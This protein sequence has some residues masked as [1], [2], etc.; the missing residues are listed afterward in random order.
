MCMR[1]SESVHTCKYTHAN[2]NEVCN[3]TY[4]MSHTRFATARNC[5]RSKSVPYNFR[6]HSSV[7]NT[8]PLPLRERY[9]ACVDFP[10][11][12]SPTNK[13]TVGFGDEDKAE[14]CA[15]TRCPDGGTERLSTN[16]KP[17]H[18]IVPTK[19]QKHKWTHPMLPLMSRTG[20]GGGGE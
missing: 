9:C 5:L 1:I 10:E 15:R 4:I 18:C 20:G 7:E 12:I 19:I 6:I 13:C 16:I 3:S 17:L 11:E 2:L 14:H 8:T